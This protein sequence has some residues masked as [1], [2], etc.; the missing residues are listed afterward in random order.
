[1]L[2]W[3]RDAKSEPPDWNLQPVI[4]K[5]TVT[6][7]VPGNAINWKIDFYNTKTGI[8]II[9]SA[10]VTRKGEK[11][12]ITLPDFKDDIAFKMVILN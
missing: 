5:Q 3:F 2:G 9:S 8:D 4:S 10:V 12:T 11:I 6:I 1:V 7:S